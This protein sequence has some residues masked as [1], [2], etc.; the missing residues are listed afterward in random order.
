MHRPVERNGRRLLQN[1][2]IKEHP[3][4]TWAVLQTISSL[5][6]G[7]S[8]ALA[9]VRVSLAFI[10]YLTNKKQQERNLGWT[11]V[12]QWPRVI[13]KIDRGTLFH[14]LYVK[15]P[16]VNTINRECSSSFTSILLAYSSMAGVTNLGYMYPR[17]YIWCTAATN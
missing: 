6:L 2:W 10:P 5:L 14:A 4:L 9:T 8:A 7:I 1:N 13:W 3:N 16:I 17:G 15:I 11:K 12:P